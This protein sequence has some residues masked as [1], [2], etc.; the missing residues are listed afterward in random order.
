[1]KEE[2]CTNKW[3]RWYRRHERGFW[4]KNE[5]EPFCH[6]LGRVF[7]NFGIQSG[8]FSFGNTTQVPKEY[9]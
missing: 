8:P 5:L 6:S 1:M 2:Q 4:F 9:R 3:E 7:G